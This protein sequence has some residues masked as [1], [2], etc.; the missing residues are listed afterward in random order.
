MQ[1]DPLIVWSI[2]KVDGLIAVPVELM[3]WKS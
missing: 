2:A 3:L 1:D